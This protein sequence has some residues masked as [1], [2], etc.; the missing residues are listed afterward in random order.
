[1]KRISRTMKSGCA[2]AMSSAAASSNMPENSA[3]IILDTASAAVS[4]FISLPASEFRLLAL[5]RRILFH[6]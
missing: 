4:V 5:R 1:M 2:D 6:S 3:G